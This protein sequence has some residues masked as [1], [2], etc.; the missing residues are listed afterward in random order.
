MQD[1]DTQ[2]PLHERIDVLRVEIR[3]LALLW[4][5]YM[6][7]NQMELHELSNKLSA[8]HKSLGAAYVAATE[9]ASQKAN[10][11]TAKG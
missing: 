9:N 1:Q 3:D 8:L 10:D 5:K 4:H 11:D 7:R 2:D 6:L